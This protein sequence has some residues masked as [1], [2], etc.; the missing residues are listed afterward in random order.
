MARFDIRQI[1]KTYIKKT[2]AMIT[3]TIPTAPAIIGALWR[4]KKFCTLVTPWGSGSTNVYLRSIIAELLGG[5]SGLKQYCLK[6]F[7][8]ISE[9][10]M[11]GVDL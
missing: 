7:V 10:G 11:T 9:R 4:V 1:E 3:I 6:Q 2:D 8:Q 5:L